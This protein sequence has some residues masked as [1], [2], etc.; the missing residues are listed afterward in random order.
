MSGAVPPPAASPLRRAA[1]VPRPVFPGRGWCGLGDPAPAPQRALL[2]AVLACCGGGGRASPGGLPCAVARGV[3]IKALSLSRPSVLLGGQ[4]GFHD[5][6]VRGAA[7]V[8]VGTQHPGP[9]ARAL[10][11]CRG[12][13]WGWWEG[14]PGGVAFCRCEGGLNS[15]TLPPAAA[16]VLPARVC[17]CG[18]QA[19][20]PW[21]APPVGGC[22]PRGWWGAVPGGVA[23]HCCEGRLVS[24][25]VPP[26]AGRP[27]FRDPCTPGPAG[28]GVGTHHARRGRRP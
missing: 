2:R 3:W 12:A 17:G 5:P 27:G 7:G 25:A 19:L 9:T 11:S 1:G 16:H 18:G 15:G 6:C 23:F 28:V 20:S 26:P 22:V 13:L 21:L 4:S 8:G 10:A 24:G 14:V